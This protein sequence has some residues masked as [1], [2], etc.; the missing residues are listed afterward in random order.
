MTVLIAAFSGKFSLRVLD[1]LYAGYG[2]ETCFSYPHITEPGDAVGTRHA[3]TVLYHALWIKGMRRL[4][5]HLPYG[6]ES[7]KGRRQYLSG[8]R[9][10]SVSSSAIGGFGTSRSRRPSFFWGS[11]NLTWDLHR[12][13]NDDREKVSHCSKAVSLTHQPPLKHT[14]PR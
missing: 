5:C 4:R 13:S 10:C 6:L 11:T 1:I 12:G 2:V 9:I 8:I 7:G 14:Q 3:W